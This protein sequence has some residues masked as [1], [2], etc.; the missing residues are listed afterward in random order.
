MHHKLVL[1][2]ENCILLTGGR[3]S[4]HDPNGMLYTLNISLNPCEWKTVKI[5]QSSDKVEPRWRHTAT[6]Y[7]LHGR[8]AMLA[9]PQ[10]VCHG[11]LLQVFCVS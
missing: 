9:A 1:V 11:F 3:R 10:D 5:H 2:S 4:P 6:S 8:V 7:K